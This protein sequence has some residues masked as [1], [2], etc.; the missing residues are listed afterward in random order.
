[1]R[2]FF[3]SILAFLCFSFATDPACGDGNTYANQEQTGLDKRFDGYTKISG[4]PSFAGGEKKLDKLIRKSLKLS[5]AAKTQVFNLNYQFT[6][7][8]DGKIKDVKQI[9]DPKANDWT[10]IGEII[11]GTEGK[12][13]PAQKDGKAVDCV[14]FRRLFVNG[15][16]Y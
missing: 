7:A 8:C 10:N 4:C 15:S 14:Y 1:M 6:V 13:T 9:G 16:Q 12:W 11:Q 3:L 2:T 5:A